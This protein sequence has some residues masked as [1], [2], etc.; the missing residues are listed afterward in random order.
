MVT[1][2]KPDALRRIC[3]PESLPFAGTE[4]LQR[5]EE[6]VSQGRAVEAI[7]FGIGMQG[8]G[9][10]LFVLGPAGTGKTTAIKRFLARE[11]SK[12]ATPPDWCYV[13]NFAD[14]QRPRA[15]R[16]PPGLAR[17]LQGDCE[18]LLAELKT[19]VPRTFETEAYEQQR[20][21]I[22]E[23]LEKQTSGELEA[24]Q[25]RAEALGFGLVKTAS[26]FMI[27]PMLR[28][29]PLKQE[30]FDALD[31]DAKRQ[32]NL[33]GEEAQK[34]MA[35]TN[36]RVREIE[37]GAKDRLDALDRE[38]ATSAVDHL[39]EEVKERYTDHP[40]VLAHF[41]AMREDVIA[42]VDLFRRG[43]GGTPGPAELIA[44]MQSGRDPLDRYRVNVLI[45]Q[46]KDGGAP[47]VVE[48]HPACQN[49]VGRIEHQVHMGALYTNFMMIKGGAL[50]RANGG[51]LVLEALEVLKQFL[52]WDQLKRTLKDRRI[53]IEEPGE[54]FRMYSTV[55]LE[56]EPIPLNVKVVLIGTPWLYYL[57][58]S[59]DPEFREL[60]KVQAEFGEFIARTPENIDA[61]ARLLATCCQEEGLS[62]FDRTAVAK[63]V[64]HSSRLVE[65]QERLATTFSDLL[66]VAR[67]AS[68]LAGQEGRDRVTADDVR[69]AIGAK[70]RRSNR[71]EERLQDLITEGTILVDTAGAAAGQVNGIAVIPLGEYHFGKPSRITARTFL[72][73]GGIIDIEREARMGGRIHS[74]GVLILSGYLGGRYARD[75][76][77]ALSGSVAFEQLYEEVE[78]DSASSA[79]L[80][81]ILSSLSGL[82]I[83][84]GLAVTG[85]VNQQGQ[86]QAIGAVNAKIEGFFDVCR[87]RGLTGDQGVLIPASNVRNLM[88]REDVVE[89]VAAGQFH[90]YPVRTIDEGIAVL[91]G[92][93]AGERA[94]D[95][96][97]PEGSV[98]GLVERRLREMAERARA[99]GGDG[100]AL[101]RGDRQGELS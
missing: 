73:R 25:R 29:K 81:A 40:E 66:D 85:S 3:Q 37:R 75:I 97:F 80:Y 99:Y 101:A 13:N 50:H 8:A 48:T 34:D 58:H 90:I 1:P 86:V 46:G 60:F 93:E 62:P 33:K 100:Q 64:E 11:A 22:L 59:F 4:D 98:N 31:E 77:L 88:L 30:G 69:R 16:L 5:L 7:A 55:T 21:A 35:A 12:L 18:R 44:M 61:F 72:G 47:V 6:I 63:L 67:E 71:L 78:G 84:Q 82:P 91:T 32:V 87:A 74:K 89:A 41:E 65:D 38:V 76:P 15:L 10:N 26:G 53:K 83:S 9:F 28:G 42:S 14:P 23:E 56:P 27:I 45:E 92:R 94:P 95:G 96:T 68:F 24:L 17:A 43:Q 51:F 49:L 20:R 79:E 2:L 54:Q 39:I 19:G 57:L 70:I 36:R 52:A